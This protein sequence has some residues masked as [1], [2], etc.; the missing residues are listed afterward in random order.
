[1][2]SSKLFRPL[3]VLAIVFLVLII[4]GFSTAC[5]QKEETPASQVK[6]QTAGV[7][8][9]DKSGQ[10]NANTQE[11][12]TE[13]AA[14]PATSVKDETSEVKEAEKTPAEPVLLA[15]VNDAEIY[16]TDLKGKP[17]DAV[18][19][20]EILYQAG[21]KQGLDAKLK[22]K[23]EDVKKKMIIN[24][25]EQEIF[26]DT[27]KKRDYTD[28]ELEDYYNENINT[29]QFLKFNEISVNDENLASEIH[30]KALAGESFED[31]ASDLSKSGAKV[32]TREIGF[33]R[34]YGNLFDS[35]EVGSVSEPFPEG[36][37][38]KV[39]RIV[40]VK[41]APLNLVKRN[42]IVAVHN[43]KKRE[44]LQSK[45]DRLKKENGIEVTIFSNG[46]K[47]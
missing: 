46:G 40:E 38:F 18:I 24:E 12:T 31:I 7:D 27:T 47:K 23:F 19:N 42:I 1:M 37:N 22:D 30:T 17:L 16:S 29:Y 32:E 8:K 44:A 39:L 33:S 6:E 10:K 41:T 2:K 9:N 21:L 26:T 14:G 43:E 15:R 20:Q 5:K 13:P 45:M 28:K 36:D 34:K 3:S 4:L 35:Y 25:V 11:K